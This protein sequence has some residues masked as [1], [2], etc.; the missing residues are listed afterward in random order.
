MKKRIVILLSAIALVICIA[1][2]ALAIWFIGTEEAYGLVLPGK[3]S[4]ALLAAMDMEAKHMIDRM[5][6]AREIKNAGKKYTYGRIGSVHVI[7]HQCGMGL[8]KA[9]AGAR[10]LIENFQPDVLV[11]F[12]MSGGIVPEIGLYETI[13]ASEVFPAWKDDWVSIKTD[14]ALAALAD[15]VLKD[16][17]LAPVATGNKMTWRK[18]DYDRIANACGAVAVDQESYAVVQAAQELGVPLLIIRSMS[19]TYE[20]SSLLGFFKHG[21]ISAE[22]A[23][24]DTASVIE[25]LAMREAH[26]AAFRYSEFKFDAMRHM[27]DASIDTYEKTEADA[28]GIYPAKKGSFFRA[29]RDG[30]GDLKIVEAAFDFETSRVICRYY[31]FEDILAL[32]CDRVEYSSHF[33]SEDTDEFGEAD[34]LFDYTILRKMIIKDGQLYYFIDDGEPLYMSNNQ[35]YLKIYEDALNA[36]NQP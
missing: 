31:P 23:A 6:D 30:N 8:D 35:D 19:D 27:R 34:E 17:Q 26:S 20:N 13:I 36:L 28:S 11:L 33:F 2:A 14:A 5:D 9:E 29:Y 16:A 10:A 18:S 32:T 15:G 12:G 7:L 25:A 1:G 22:K 4:V 3:P 24:E 21:P